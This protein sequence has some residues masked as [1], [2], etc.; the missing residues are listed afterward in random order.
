MTERSVV[1][2]NFTIERTYAAA[3]ARVFAAWSTEE[4]LLRWAS[5]GEGWEVAY[6]HFDFRT[7]GGDRNRFGPKG[8]ETYVTESRYEDIVRDSRIV[9]SYSMTCAGR[10]LF[11][12][13]LTVELYPMAAGTRLFLTEQGVYLD[14]SDLPENHRVGWGT[15]LDKLAE[16]VGRG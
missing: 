6:D 9:S 13:L 2:G 3:P 8:G 16:E 11:V 5:P 10:R 1:H 7:G 15:M 12:G 14:G 4:A